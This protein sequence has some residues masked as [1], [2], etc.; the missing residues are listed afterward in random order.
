M[1]KNLHVC[2]VVSIDLFWSAHHNLFLRRAY[3]ALGLLHETFTNA[4]S[5]ANKKMLYLSLVY[6]Q[7]MYYCCS[8]CGVHI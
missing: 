1:Y 4:L 5:I 6:S 8:Q 2:V 3:E 7:L